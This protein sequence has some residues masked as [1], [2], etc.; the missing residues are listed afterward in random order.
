MEEKDY[1]SSLGYYTTTLEI[2]LQY[3]DEYSLNVTI[4]NLSLLMQEWDADEA[5]D[6]LAVDD[7]IK[8]LLK[9]ISKNKSE[10]D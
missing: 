4:R 6:A 8:E 2:F 10:Q 9:K 7:E 1:A 3:N 5:I